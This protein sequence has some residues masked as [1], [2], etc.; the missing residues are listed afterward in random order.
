M[1][2]VSDD[3]SSWTFPVVGIGASA[4]GIQALMDF[5][6]ALPASTGVAFIVVQHLSPD[7]PSIL[8]DLLAKRA[9]L[10]VHKAADGTEV[11]VDSVY[12]ASPG[13]VISLENGFI[14][15]RPQVG[16]T[17][18]NAIDS[19]FESLA[20][21]CGSK[22]IAVVLS[23]TGSDG[24]AGAVQVKRAGGMV[25]VQDPESAAHSGMPGST[26]A[27][28]VVDHVAPIEALSL[29]LLAAVAKSEH[30]TPAVENWTNETEESLREIIALVS[31]HA[32][33]D[34][35][36]YKVTPLLWRV[37]RRLATR[38]ITR[39]KD[40]LDLL[41]DDLAELES[42]IRGLPIHVT[43]FFRDEKAWAV[44]E[45]QVIQP[46]IANNDGTRPIRVW[47]TACST[48]EEAYSIAML[49]ADNCTHADGK[50]I[51]FQIFATD[52]LPEVVTKAARG[53]YSAK[54]I[55][56]LGEARRDRYFY[57]VDGC[58]RVKQELREK[59][60]FAPQRLLHDHGFNDLDL[61]TCRNLLIYLQPQAQQH[62]LR[63]LHT[64]LRMGGCLFLGNSESLSPR[65]G[66]YKA[67][68]AEHRIYRKIGDVEGMKIDLSKR[69]EKGRAQQ[70]VSET[71]HLTLMERL[72]LPSVLV[73]TEL[74]ILRLYGDTNEFLRLP[75]GEPSLD[76]YRVLDPQLRTLVASV[77]RRAVEDGQTASAV[78]R[79]SDDF[80][81]ALTLRVTPL[82]RENGKI[83]R[84]LI[85]FLG[86]TYH[87]FLD[88]SVA[89]S[90]GTGQDELRL[91]I[92]ELDA[93]REELQALNEELRAVNEQLNVSNEEVNKVNEAL[94][95]KISELETQSDVLSSGRVLTLFIDAQW[96]I[97]WFTPAITELFPLR[98]SD[99]GRE[100]TEFYPKFNDETFLPDVEK[101]M[102]LGQVQEGETLGRNGKWYQRHIRPFKKDA[103][104]STGV[105]IT[106]A[107]I[108]AR[109][110]AEQALQERQIWLSCQRHALE[111]AL[112]GR[113]L[114]ESLGAL[115]RCAVQS[116]G[117]GT[118]AA[119]YLAN[120]DG[121]LHHLVGMSD[122]SAA[123]V[124]GFQTHTG[125]PVITVDVEEEPL[126]E[127][128]RDM[129]RRHN[130]RACWS[131]PIRTTVGKFVGT[132]AFY[133]PHPTD[134]TERELELASLLT[135]TAAILIAH[136]METAVRK[137]T[138]QALL[139]TE[140]RLK[141]L[142]DG[143]VE[144]KK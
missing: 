33:I 11:L 80:D 144:K 36:S 61:V 28:G 105:A 126:W 97:R 113:T 14:R 15:S 65:Q 133:F 4:G 23:G 1:L 67:I 66:G 8:V 10:S 92:E 37:Q 107:D 12:V 13:Q 55:E 108:T 46:L 54:A 74:N 134:A 115:I 78:R 130:Y 53:Q 119:F 29:E 20:E 35:A 127:R 125:A 34:F 43:S 31:R 101:V 117:A 87:G 9:S 82:A 44:L 109:K 83:D 58:F 56:S 141:T 27:M 112:D 62:V 102:L 111:S 69:I 98:K 99:I 132:L 6:S 121:N 86:V 60:V 93:S 41:H 122:A 81:D 140:R 16:T 57:R 76:L 21:A 63:L 120:S 26:I 68:A 90:E 19:L 88:S 64:A 91:S 123:A 139:E 59:I 94:R 39:I 25:C 89:K 47:T 143:L 50:K 32:D 129:A 106:F 100:I 5:F 84:L 142:A 103:A 138:E 136:Q 40:Y 104:E 124:D 3:K 42:L 17:R 72:D 95:T 137:E 131:F 45:R 22:G 18:T 128:W 110:L 73:D 49:L 85:S 30:A 118:Q 77:V 51:D 96:R 71:T 48:G 38:R 135:H 7:H 24:A 79:A 52:A 75:A 116:L 2:P 114:P 70:K